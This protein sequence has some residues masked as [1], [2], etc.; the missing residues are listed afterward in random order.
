M[1]KILFCLL[2]LLFS[3][4]VY[5]CNNS[6]KS[7]QK[8]L[9][10]NVNFDLGYSI[11]ND[12]AV[13]NLII[14]GLN[15]DLYITDENGKVIV[16]DK[17]GVATLQNLSNGKNKY[18]IYSKTYSYCSFGVLLTRT[19]NVPNYNPYYNDE[20]CKNHRSS[21]LCNR[22]NNLELSYDEFK[23]AILKL[24]KE[25]QSVI[26]DDIIV[27]KFNIFDYIIWIVFGTIL[28]SGSIIYIAKRKSIGF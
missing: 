27:E 12:K 26:V 9:A 19:I 1:K 14:T 21:D 17:N 6:I 4:Y 5:A 7:S 10:S 8:V 24:E 15:E 3:P 20:L 28:L 25:Q 22:W 2:V 13:F 18:Y 23:Q 11:V 16:S